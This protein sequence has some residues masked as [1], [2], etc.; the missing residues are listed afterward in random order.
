MVTFL[1]L[2]HAVD[3][4]RSMVTEIQTTGPAL[5]IP[6]IT[7]IASLM[8]WGFIIYVVVLVVRVLHRLLRRL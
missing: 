1:A 5:W 7:T 8:V 4:V 6:L 3:R 2:H